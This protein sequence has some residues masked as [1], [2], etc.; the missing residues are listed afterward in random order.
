MSKTMKEMYEEIREEEYDNQ[1]NEMVKI[2]DSHFN[3][4]VVDAVSVT[5][6]ICSD[7]NGGSTD[8]YKLP[9]NAT[10]LQDLIEAKNM[11]FAIGNIFKACYRMGNVSHSDAIRDL[12]KIIWFAQR[13]LER[14]K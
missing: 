8:Y 6:K 1:V 13:E 10:E 9:L 7:N 4:K 12:N 5:E 2:I 11:N 14:L 3:H